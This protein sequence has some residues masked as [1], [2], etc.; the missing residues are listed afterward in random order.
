LRPVP[1]ADAP[2]AS[3]AL[4]SSHDGVVG[5][6]NARVCTGSVA[7][8]DRRRAGFSPSFRLDSNF[9]LLFGPPC[10]GGSVVEKRGVACR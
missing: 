4:P 5:P 6:L 2:S 7:R 9:I 10:D 8:G 3:A 1:D